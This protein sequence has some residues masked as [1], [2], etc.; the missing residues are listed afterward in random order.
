MKLMC[1]NVNGIRAVSKKGFWEWIA[2]ENPDIVCLQETKANPSQLEPDM[3]KPPGYT[4]YWA[5]AQKPGYS[6]VALLVKKTP[7]EVKVGMGIPEFDNEG[8]SLIAVYADFILFNGYFPN[9][10][11]DLSRVDYKLRFS[12]SAKNFMLDLKNRLGKPLIICG[13]VNTAH[14]EIDI[15]R[16]KENQGTT[17]FLPQERAWVKQF[18]ESGFID[19]FRKRHPAEIMYSWWSYRA[20]AR[21][22]NVGWR[23]DYF[24]IT[25]E[26]ESRVTKT[27]YQNE[28]FGSDHCPVV[29][30]L[31]DA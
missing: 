5:S 20:M 27:Y 29:L 8:R 15:A 19:I 12:E 14:Q 31:A 24:F 3:I 16:P 23:I 13:D 6:G 2:R 11:D 28:V 10:K 30:E 22:R 4:T 18:I 21:E 26:L 1:W 17:G 9:G 25:P 7:L